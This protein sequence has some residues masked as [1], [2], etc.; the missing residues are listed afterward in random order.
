[1]QARMSWLTKASDQ[2]IGWAQFS[3]GVKSQCLWTNALFGIVETR[4]RFCNVVFSSPP[5]T[6]RKAWRRFGLNSPVHTHS[7]GFG[8]TGMPRFIALHLCFTD[9]AF[10]QIEDKTLHQRKDDDSLYCCTHFSAVVW[11]RT[12]ISPSYA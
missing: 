7:T 5:Q 6:W 8:M 2:N 9:G 10:S 4:R 1:M 11:N 3:L 12:A